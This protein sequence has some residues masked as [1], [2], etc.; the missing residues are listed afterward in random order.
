MKKTFMILTL[1]STT[2]AFAQTQDKPAASIDSTTATGNTQTT[3]VDVNGN[4]KV[5][6]PENTN[7]PTPAPAQKTTVQQTETTETTTTTP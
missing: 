6:T 7:P 4:L 2:I 3:V 5:M 1:L